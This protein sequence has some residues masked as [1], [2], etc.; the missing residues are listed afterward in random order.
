MKINKKLAI[1]LSFTVGTLMFA[2]TAMAEVAS[3]SGYDQLKDSLKYT[4]NSLSSK[5][6]S[7]TLDMSFAIK[8]NN[9]VISSTNVL[10][11]C[12]LSKG[13][14]EQTSKST[15]TLEANST[16]ESYYYTDKNCS[17]SHN[18]D[19]DFY[20]VIELKDSKD[21][22]IFTDPFKEKQAADIEKISDALVGNLKDSVVVTQNTDGSKKLSGSLTEAQIP[23][24]VNALASFQFKNQFRMYNPDE[25]TSTRAKMS[26]ITKDIFVKE[27]KGTMDVNKDGLIQ[28]VIFTGTLSGK[29]EQGTEHTLTFELLAKVTNINSTTVNKPDLSDKKVQK[30]VQKDDNKL[31]NAKA[32]IGKYKTDLVIQKDNKFVK[33]GERI[34]T[35]TNIND[36]SVI[37]NYHEEYIK[38]YE[39]YGNIK[40]DFNFD[41]K[42]NKQSHVDADF[43]CTNSSGKTVKGHIFINHDSSS[44]YFTINGK[45]PGENVLFND[46]FNR[47][48]E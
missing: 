32:Y 1:I 8:D 12:D 10:N 20:R 18:S 33:I 42:F 46:S 40:N 3:K 24:I 22:K 14:K 37:G 41:G 6:S 36:D 9:T 4:G 45:R 31:S 30:Q 38:G 13:A 16:G 48:F 15:N 21:K 28:N 19:E 29:D 27:V 25:A 47:V 11:K 7:Y 5:L 17:I 43:S 44:M 26:K 34:I 2:S 23:A 39:S 35:I